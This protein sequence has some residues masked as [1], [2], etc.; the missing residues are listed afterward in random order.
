MS[1][2][3]RVTIA[4]VAAATVA[5]GSLATPQPASAVPI[6]C[7][8][9]SMISAMHLFTV[10]ALVA[11]GQNLSAHYFYGLAEGLRRGSCG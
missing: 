8:A 3:R 9:A 10:K 6:S 7:E 4:T 1:R 11:L 2:V 5:V